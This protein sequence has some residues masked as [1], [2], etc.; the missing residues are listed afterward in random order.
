MIKDSNIIALSCNQLG[1]KESVKWIINID[2]AVR[3]EASGN[4]KTVEA[5]GQ[6]MYGIVSLSEES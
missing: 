2:Q 5:N 4:M 3:D 1:G 6:D